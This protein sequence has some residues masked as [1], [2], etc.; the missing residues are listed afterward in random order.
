[1]SSLDDEITQYIADYA[2]QK[3]EQ[4]KAL[5]DF[6]TDA[7]HADYLVTMAQYLCSSHLLDEIRKLKVKRLYDWRYQTNIKGDDVDNDI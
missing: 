6:S 2:L 4:A 1:M 3:Y 7:G 5:K